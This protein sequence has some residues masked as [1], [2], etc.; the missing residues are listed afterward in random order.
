MNKNKNKKPIARAASTTNLPTVAQHRVEAVFQDSIKSLGKA[1]R[2]VA[3]DAHDKCAKGTQEHFLS[4]LPDPRYNSNWTEEDERALEQELLAS[5]EFEDHMIVKTTLIGVYKTCYLATGCLVTD[6]VGFKTGLVWSSDFSRVMNQRWSDTFIERMQRI[7]CHP[8][9]RGNV[10]WMRLALQWSVIC[11]TDDRRV[12]LLNGAKSDVF[13]R[14]LSEVMFEVQSDS[15]PVR[16]S[17]LRRLALRLYKQE[18][19]YQKVRDPDWSELMEGIEA[20]VCARESR[21]IKLDED[22]PFPQTYIITV[23][24]AGAVLAALDNMQALAFPVY[25]ASETVRSAAKLIQTVNDWPR[26][27]E[28]KMAIKAVLLSEERE[29]RIRARLGAGLRR[30]T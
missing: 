5:P 21:G 7:I 1:L 24:D 11:R 17:A 13:L 6:I 30:P 4:L 14:M 2:K 28:T 26:M 9:F 3:E 16:P 27:R 29:L 15:D 22:D 18:H 20:L 10:L 12:H 8:F 25:H 23:D 19:A